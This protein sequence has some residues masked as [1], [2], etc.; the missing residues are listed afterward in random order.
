MK[1]L[2]ATAGISKPIDPAILVA[3]VD[4]CLDPGFTGELCQA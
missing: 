2:G 4:R 3:A 1:A